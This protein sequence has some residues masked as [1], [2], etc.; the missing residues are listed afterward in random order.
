MLGARL[1]A[2]AGIASKITPL[3]PN[4]TTSF[5]DTEV[6][7]DEGVTLEYDAI[8]YPLAVG[9]TA[10]FAAS[11]TGDELDGVMLVGTTPLFFLDR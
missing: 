5:V 7:V 9:S 6:P 11:A 1:V 4:L 8:A 10:V 3:P 2:G